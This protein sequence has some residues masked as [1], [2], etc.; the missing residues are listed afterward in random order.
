MRSVVLR[1]AAEDGAAAKRWEPLKLTNHYD[2]A[3]TPLRPRNDTPASAQGRTQT[4][5]LHPQ[6]PPPPTI[7]C[8]R[9]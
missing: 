1:F 3:A 7:P 2:P 5:P 4:S 9:L 8:D 6:R